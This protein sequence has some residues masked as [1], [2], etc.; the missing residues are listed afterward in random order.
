MRS[1]FAAALLAL[2]VL[3]NS[4]SLTLC[5]EEPPLT[6]AAILPLSGAAAE[7]GTACRNGITLAYEG[8]PAE[9]RSSI[10]LI[11]EDNGLTAA[12]A[13][14]AFKKVVS[15]DRAAV[16]VT[17]D[18]GSSN[19]L[20]PLCEEQGITLVT[21]SLD[22]RIVRG[23]ANA[24]NYWVTPEAQ[25]QALIDES[26]RR[27]Y[28]RLA[29]AWAIHDGVLSIKSAFDRRNNG[30]IEVAA[31]EEFPP[32]VQDFRPMLAKIRNI[33]GI[34]AIADNLLFG[35]VGIFA[36]QAREL[37]LSQPIIGIESFE[38]KSEVE[39]SQGA[40]LGQWYVQSADAGPDFRTAY[41][42]RFP[43]AS[44]YSA[45]H[46]HD[47]MT[48]IARARTEKKL[49]P[50]FL[51]ALKDFSGAMGTVSA[52]GDHRFSLGAVVKKVTPAGFELAG[53]E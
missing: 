50:E 7:G 10:R 48:L 43:G 19:A 35:Q 36:K 12:R 27:G 33:P 6:V 49:L 53:T 21:S 37:G 45:G 2:L 34:D 5:A 51:H 17:W 30:R 3:I 26:L 31:A 28:K 40:L 11:F 14:S 25:A 29:M 41:L 9:A 16:I 24:F 8:L 52:T 1:I 44:L 32:E 20:A 15:V 46:C 13:L 38:E 23:R 47:I 4:A 42:K 22:P 18:S 39:A